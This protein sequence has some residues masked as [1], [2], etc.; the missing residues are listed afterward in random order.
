MENEKRDQVK[1]FMLAAYVL[2]GVLLIVSIWANALLTRE[3]HGPSF[4]RATAHVDNAVYLSQ[5]A[6]ASSGTMIPT[7][8]HKN[9]HSTP[10][11]E[12]LLTTTPTPTE[13][14]DQVN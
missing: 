5:T 10:I 9:E 11:P 3:P 12:W 14:V 4:Y 1:N 8:A 2:V 6:D 7:K 13:G